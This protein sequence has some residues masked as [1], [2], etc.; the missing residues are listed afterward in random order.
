MKWMSFEGKI[1]PGSPGNP[2]V[3]LWAEMKIVDQGPAILH[4]RKEDFIDVTF[5]GKTLKGRFFD[6][7][8]RRAGEIQFFF[9]KAKEDQQFPEA[10]M[11]KIASR[12]LMVKPIIAKKGEKAKSL[13]ERLV[14]N[15]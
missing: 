12:Q 11:H 15:K 14:T 4:R 6:R 1:P 7:M 9:W 8:V 13:L 3:N 10:L 5:L 2:T